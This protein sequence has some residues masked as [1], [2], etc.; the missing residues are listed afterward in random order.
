MILKNLDVG[1][2][3]DRRQ[4]GP[5]DLAPGDILGVQDAPFGMSAFAA[6]VQFAQA[7]DLALGELHAQ[8]DQ[9]RDARRPFLDNGAHDFLVAKPRPGLKG[10]AHVNR[11]G[12]LLA[13][14]GRDAALGVIG[15]GL[16]AGFSW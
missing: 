15:I 2:R 1:L 5:L 14:D 10:V 9:F 13:D 11:E 8:F 7:V 3:G 16:G 4:Q 12:I 6:Q